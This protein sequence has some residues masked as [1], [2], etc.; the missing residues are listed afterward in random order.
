M[1]PT[2]SIFSSCRVRSTCRFTASPRASSLMPG[3]W[4]MPF[5]LRTFTSV[6]AGNTVSWCAANTR[7]GPSPFNVP[8]RTAMTLP[9]LSIVT[10]VRPSSLKRRI[11]SS[12]RVFSWKGGASTSVM[13]IWSA[14]VFASSRFKSSRHFTIRGSALS[15]S[16]TVVTSA[17]TGGRSFKS[18]M[19]GS[20]HQ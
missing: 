11:K 5:S 18:N 4:R 10:S 15:L 1:S 19:R 8:G 9:S 6:P 14:T 2:V 3:A 17:L 20:P 13:A 16:A 12:P 7:C